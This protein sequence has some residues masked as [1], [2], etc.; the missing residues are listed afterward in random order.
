MGNVK[1]YHIL[2]QGKSKSHFTA[3]QTEMVQEDLIV[4]PTGTSGAMRPGQHQPPDKEGRRF[5]V[6][7]G[8]KTG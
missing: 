8:E 4:R 2:F 5:P 6:V 3:E 7:N 1:M